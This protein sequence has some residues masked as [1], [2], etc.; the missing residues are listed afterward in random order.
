MKIPKIFES[1]YRFC[2]LLWGLVAVRLL[3]PDV[4]QSAMSLILSGETISPQ[5][6]QQT[7][8]QIH[9]GISL[10]NNAVNPTLQQMAAQHT[11]A[12]TSP[13]E[14]CL[15]SAVG[16]WLVGVALLM[17]YTAASCLRL[18][19]RVRTAVRVHDNIF[20]SKFVSTPF[21]LGV[22]AACFLTHPPEE[23]LSASDLN[24]TYTGSVCL[25]S[26]PL[27]S[28]SPPDGRYYEQIIL[29]EG[30]LLVVT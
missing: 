12:G 7:V 18:R 17:L 25:G 24:G 23:Q 6:M 20:Q 4:P 29:L 26:G 16:V 15:R 28:Y 14:N 30:K 1:E 19:A 3:C 9:S 27:L 10:M 2:L 21:V 8:S 13:L 22:V 11:V 5:I